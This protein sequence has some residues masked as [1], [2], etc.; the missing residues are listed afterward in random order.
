M[1]HSKPNS[2]VW[3][4][5][6]DDANDEIQIIE[7]D[8]E[9]LVDDFDGQCCRTY[10][11]NHSKIQRWREERR[12]R[13]ETKRASQL[14]KKELELS[15]HVPIVKT[16]TTTLESSVVSLKSSETISTTAGTSIIYA[17]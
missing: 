9:V 8:E 2:S 17:L 5:S 6:E 15:K 7:E 3:K 10:P 16:P 4:P 11:Y 14:Q 13:E 1:S 12:R